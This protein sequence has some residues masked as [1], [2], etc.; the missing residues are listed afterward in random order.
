[1][2]AQGPADLVRQLLLLGPQRLERLQGRPARLVGPQQI[3]HKGLRLTPGTLAGL[4]PIRVVA[5]LSQVNHEPSV[6]GR[7]CRPHSISDALSITRPALRSG[8]T[9]P[10]AAAPTCRDPRP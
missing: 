7:S 3:V 10:T 9:A 1:L 5:E 8:R 2:L 4:Y 6:P